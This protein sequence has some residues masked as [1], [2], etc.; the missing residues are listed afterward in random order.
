MLEIYAD[1]EFYVF[2]NTPKTWRIRKDKLQEEL[3]RLDEQLERMPKP[4]LLR[5][6]IEPDEEVYRYAKAIAR[7]KYVNTL[8]V[9]RNMGI[10]IPDEM[11]RL[12]RIKPGDTLIIRPALDN[13]TPVLILEKMKEAGKK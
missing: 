7:K 10:R 12:L 11:A 5:A 6:V 3:L 1:D 4:S 13:L 9:S 8:K 2:K